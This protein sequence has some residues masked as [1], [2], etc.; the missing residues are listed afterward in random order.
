MEKFLTTSPSLLP[1]LELKAIK[2]VY[3]SVVANDGVDLQIYPGEIHALLGENGAGKSTLMKIVYGAVFPTSGVMLWDGEKIQ[4]EN[5]AH[6]RKLGIGMVFQHFSLFETL[7]VYEN[8]LLGLDSPPP[9]KELV[10]KIKEVS[11]H[12][13]L[14]LEPNRKVHA[15]SVGERQR[16]EIIRCLLQNPKLLIMDEPTAVLTPQAVKKLFFTL[17][18]LA[19]EGCAILYISHKLD[20]IKEL[21]DTATVLRNGRVVAHCKPKEET[22]QS[23]ARMMIGKDLPHYN[24]VPFTETPGIGLEINNLSLESE[25]PFGVSL[26]NIKLQVPFG[27]IVGLAGVSGNGQKELLYALSGEEPL[28]DPSAIFIKGKP[29]GKLSPYQRRKLGFYFIPEERLGRGAVP[30]LNLSDNALLTMVQKGTVQLGMVNF[31]KVRDYA[32]KCITNF[33]VKCFGPLDEAQSLSG[34]NLQKFILGRDLLQSPDVL[35]VA[36]PTWGVDV[37]AAT[38]IRQTL[39]DLCQK[40]TAILVVSEELDELFEICDSIAV[41][42]KGKISPVKKVAKT[43]VEEIGLWMSGLWENENLQTPT[44]N[45]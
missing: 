28:K 16:V 18:N 25:D 34:G 15:L 12:Y 9:Q 41:I 45:I 17:K 32:Q 2:K 31:K 1:L 44:A 20:E 42:A 14:P 24:R 43:N 4:I 8:I 40:N 26:K 21:C 22:E 38:F 39:L 27:R 6:A 13:G 3:P 10:A 36:Q 37:N 19:K 30:D 11:E 23:M 33:Q 5:P 7:S 29:A 35:V